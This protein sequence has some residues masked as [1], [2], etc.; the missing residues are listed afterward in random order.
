MKEAWGDENEPD[1][2]LRGL[3]L[4]DDMDEAYMFME[5]VDLELVPNYCAYVAFPT[6]VGTIK[7]R[8]R[9]GFYR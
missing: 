2:I 3:D 1:R 6:D 4:I 8:L 5:P 7:E 9:N